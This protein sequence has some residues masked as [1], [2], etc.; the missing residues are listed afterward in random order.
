MYLSTSGGNVLVHFWR[1]IQKRASVLGANVGKLQR[2]FLWVQRPN[3]R[4]PKDLVCVLCVTCHRNNIITTRKRK[5]KIN[6]IV[7]TTKQDPAI[8]LPLLPT[9]IIT[10][11]Y[12]TCASW[13]LRKWVLISLFPSDTFFLFQSVSTRNILKIAR[14]NVGSLLYSVWYEDEELTGEGRLIKKEGFTRFMVL[15][16][17]PRGTQKIRYCMFFTKD[18]RKR[19]R[20]SK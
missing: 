17:L 2:R 15:Y 19:N 14:S 9:R 16:V 18:L 8:G 5:S 7:P 11:G 20:T 13:H 12:T 6:R 4:A 1:T 3:G 10:Y